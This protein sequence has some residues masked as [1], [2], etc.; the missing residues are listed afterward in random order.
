MITR[1]N[2]YVHELIGLEAEVV[3]SNCKNLLHTKGMVVDETKNTL[4]VEK[5]GKPRRIPKNSCT[6]RFRLPN[7]EFVDIRGAEILYAPEER[8]KKLFRKKMV[9]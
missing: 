5:N 8:P 6:F 9:L 1:R 7:S 2:V 4:M 3:K